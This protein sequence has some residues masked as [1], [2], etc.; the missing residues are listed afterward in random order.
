MVA[1][2]WELKK[3]EGD[4]V[5]TG[6]EISLLPRGRRGELGREAKREVLYY[7]FESDRL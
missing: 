6:R 5:I 1:G 2:A 3:I 4:E 7:I